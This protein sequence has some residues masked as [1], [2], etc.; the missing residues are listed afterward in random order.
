[1]PGPVKSRLEDVVGLESKTHRKFCDHVI[2]AIDRHRKE[3]QKLR[4]QERAVQRKVSQLQLTELTNK[5]KKK[6]QAPV[7][8][9]DEEA[10]SGAIVAP[11]VA[12]PSD[13][14]IHHQ[15][16]APPPQAPPVVYVYI[17]Q[18]RGRGKKATAQKGNRVVETVLKIHGRLNRKKDGGLRVSPLKVGTPVRPIPWVGL[19]TGTRDAQRILLGRAN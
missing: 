16:P 11:A 5:S 15:S 2:H 6:V 12:V 9:D 14:P 4:E 3:E 7:L 18:P 19:N 1:M 8:N 13:P 10:Q 17:Q